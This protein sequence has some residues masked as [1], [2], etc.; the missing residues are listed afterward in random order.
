MPTVS[1]IDDEA[2]DID[3]AS[4]PLTVAGRPM[5]VDDLRRRTRTLDAVLDC[6]GGW[7]STQRWD[8]VAVADLL[9]GS[10]ARSF[11]VRSATGYRRLFPMDDA[12]VDVRRRRLRRAGRCGAATA[13]RCGIVAPSRRGP[14]WVKWVVAIEPSIAAVVAAAPV[15]ADVTSRARTFLHLDRPPR[16]PI[17]VRKSGCIAG[18]TAYESSCGTM[19]LP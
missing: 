2:P 16:R 11:E 8:V 6:T 19:S 15:P 13:R 17:Q 14:W 1:W 9:A 10:D 5:T 7:C 12:G 18:V 4:W 3:E